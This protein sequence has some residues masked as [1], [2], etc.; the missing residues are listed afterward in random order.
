MIPWRDNPQVLDVPPRAWMHRLK[1]DCFVW[2][3]KE[4]IF[5]QVRIPW[6]PLR[7]GRGE[8]VLQKFYENRAG[9]IEIWYVNDD[10]TGIDSSQ[11]IRPV[12]GNFTEE[13]LQP[14]VSSRFE[15]IDMS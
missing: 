1:K 12:E 2:L 10:G 14:D 8:L 11:I 3:C 6:S 9:P 4:Q 13:P 7:S 15:A 5:A